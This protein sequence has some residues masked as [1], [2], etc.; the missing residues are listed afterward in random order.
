MYNA[1]HGDEKNYTK[2][3]RRKKIMAFNCLLG[4]RLL[5][6][7]TQRSDYL[8]PHY[9]FSAQELSYKQDTNTNPMQTPNVINH[10]YLIFHFRFSL[11]LPMFASRDVRPH[12]TRFSPALHSLIIH[13][14]PALQYT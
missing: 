4:A 6:Y 12:T 8:S 13:A 10:P 9:L 2:T 14:S 3:S 11:S 7:F 5:C 1:Y